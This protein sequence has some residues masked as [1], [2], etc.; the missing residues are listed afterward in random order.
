MSVAIGIV[1]LL[2]IFVIS[3]AVIRKKIYKE[4]DRLEAWKIEIM[5]RP[6]SNEIAKI[7][8]INMIGESEKKFEQ[9]R[10]DWEQIVT[11]SLPNLE[12][13]LFDAEE[14]SDKY[15]FRKAKSILA[16]VRHELET[17]E[18]QLEQILTEVNQWVESD[19]K[20][21]SEIV[22]LKEEYRKGKQYL[23]THFSSFGKAS[24]L[25]EEAFQK[26]DEGFAR[27]DSATNDGNY[28][29]AR[30]IL[31]ETKQLL[32]TTKE[33]METI[34]E[35]FLKLRSELPA[36]VKELEDGI[37][38][39]ERQGY[40]IDRP[41][42]LKELD[43]IRQQIDNG[44]KDVEETRVKEAEKTVEQINEKIDALYEWLEKEVHAKQSVLKERAS[45][46]KK[47]DDMKKAVQALKEETQ[48]V[49]ESYR[50]DDKDLK[51]QLVL[52]KK[53]ETLMTRFRLVEEAI[54]SQGET[55]TSLAEIVEETKNGLKELEKLNTK[56]EEMLKNLRKDELEAKTTIQTLKRRLFNAK[57]LIQKHNLPGLPFQYRSIVEATEEKII[58]VEQKLAEKPLDIPAINYA[59][60]KALE[61]VD[62]CIMRTEEIVEQALLAEKIIQ[63]GNRYRSSYPF[64]NEA[65]SKA[66]ES[67][68]C[69]DYGEAL[70]TAAKAIEQI[71]ADALK[72]LHIELEKMEPVHT[73][74]D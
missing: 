2:A 28:P 29:E 60:K 40:V 39:M 16:A 44:L 46:K 62:E 48:M 45:L 25:L 65:L 52:E 71:D 68:R 14:A 5:N 70:E 59:L 50:I 47:L 34:P 11:V 33:T 73:A 17:I 49:S 41:S 1:V 12:E 36:K 19:E 26:V 66:E 38:D 74:N 31:L 58:D 43:Q 10:N 30:Q 13:K 21:R 27:Y 54:E 72:K 15:R 23:L 64:V 63:Y 20:N 32:M 8:T 51:S 24:Y 53:L 57:R 9:W 37:D 18:Q 67:F 42:F 56:Y 69:Y 6:V 55:Y 4:V 7:K 35:L 61:S 22:S 3:A